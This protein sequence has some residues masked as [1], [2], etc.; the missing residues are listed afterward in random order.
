M[1]SQV[2]DCDV[3][4][5]ALYTKINEFISWINLKN[6]AYDVVV[7]GKLLTTPKYSEEIV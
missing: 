2:H 7:R 6:K 5:H 1:V 3:S 4:K